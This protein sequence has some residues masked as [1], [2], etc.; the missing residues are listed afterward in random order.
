MKDRL[1]PVPYWLCL[2]GM[3]VQTALGAL[4]LVF[5]RSARTGTLA[6]SARY[7]LRVALLFEAQ[8]VTIDDEIDS[9]WKTAESD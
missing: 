3:R 1:F 7:V 8:V 6:R 4:W 9:L 2:E 5:F